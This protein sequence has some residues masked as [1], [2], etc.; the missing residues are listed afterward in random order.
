MPDQA[1][2]FEL[3][4]NAVQLPHLQEFEL[5]KTTQGGNWIL[6][7]CYAR[8]AGY[9]RLFAAT[10]RRVS[11]RLIWELVRY[12]DLARIRD[13]HRVLPVDGYVMN[14]HFTAYVARHIAER[15]PEWRDLFDIRA[16]R[17]GRKPKK[18]VTIQQF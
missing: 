9:A 15:K 16:L 12:L 13:E 18:I 3:P 5:W 17:T 2:Q 10:G 1:I 7:R 4:L 11:I 8:T 14:D 6:E